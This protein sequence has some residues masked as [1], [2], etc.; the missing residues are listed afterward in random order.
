[1]V[2]SVVVKYMHDTEVARSHSI[3][4]DV[5]S[6]YIDGMGILSY[7]FLY[8]RKIMGKASTCSLYWGG[9]FTTR[10]ASSGGAGWK[11]AEKFAAA[12]YGRTKFLSPS[13]GLLTF[14][15]YIPYPPK[16]DII[17]GLQILKSSSLTLLP[18]L[19]L[20]TSNSVI[21]KVCSCMH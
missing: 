6:W 7:L 9:I 3:C 2:E 20:T 4:I 11:A 12:I 8:V 15:L 13:P 10:P 1:M 17:W 18:L 14:D 5:Q 19:L 21:R 16:Q